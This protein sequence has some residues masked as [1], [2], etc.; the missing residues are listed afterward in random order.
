MS[1]RQLRAHINQTVDPLLQRFLQQ[2]SQAK[3]RGI[4]WQLEFWQWLE[5]W[6]AS[7]HL[8]ERG[9]SSDHQAPHPPRTPSLDDHLLKLEGAVDKL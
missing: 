4:P 9:R 6:Q 2:R 1:L 7:G 8:E 5:I 3:Q